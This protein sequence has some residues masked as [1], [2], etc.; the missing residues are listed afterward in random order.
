MNIL[1]FEPDYESTYPPLGLMKLAY[2]H[3]EHRGDFVWLAKG[4]LPKGV[5]EK[6]MGQLETSK[7][8][9]A[10]YE[11][12]DFAAHAEDV[13]Q[14]RRWDR[15]YVT[16]LFTY[17]WTKTV[18][19]IEYA[20]TLVDDVSQVFVG[21][22]LATLMPEELEAATGIKPMTGLLTDSAA[23]GFADHVNIDMLTPDYSILDLIE[24]HY[25]MS[26]HYIIRATRGCGM[27]C[28]FCAVQT[29]NCSG[30]RFG[31]AYTTSLPGQSISIA[32][33]LGR[34]LGRYLASEVQ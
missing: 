16:S 34:E 15:V 8:Y 14:N 30:G 28:S 3:K 12:E 9:A 11:L 31:T 27:K 29:G 26:E 1:L 20:K 23:L 24:H 7:Y 2:Y 18:A 32:Q 5:S 25:P 17:E 10:R 4:K 19:A 6:V 22:I 33:T 21:G 13:I